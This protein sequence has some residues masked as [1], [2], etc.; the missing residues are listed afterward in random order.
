M[1]RSA[2]PFS[3]SSELFMADEERERKKELEVT[4][5]TAWLENGEVL[6]FFFLFLLEDRI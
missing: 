1:G 4:S 6:F 2:D 5:D 3:E